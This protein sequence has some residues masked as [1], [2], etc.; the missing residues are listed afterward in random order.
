MQYFAVSFTTKSL[1]VGVLIMKIMPDMKNYKNNF[2]RFFLNPT[3]FFQKTVKKKIF[4]GV[5]VRFEEPDGIHPSGSSNLGSGYC[6]LRFA[7]AREES[8]GLSLL[9][10]LSGPAFG[11]L[12]YPSRKIG[13]PRAAVP[14]YQ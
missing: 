2:F 1:Y 7:P 14:V 11:C 4:S 3:V 13:L 12:S 10:F 5:P 8:F 9:R 6:R